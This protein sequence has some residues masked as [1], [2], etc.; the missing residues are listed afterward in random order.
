MV[1]MHVKKHAYIVDRAHAT[2]GPRAEAPRKYRVPS[3]TLSVSTPVSTLIPAPI[4]APS[5]TRIVGPNSEKNFS[6]KY[7]T[8]LGGAHAQTP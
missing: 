7:A 8:E 1:L 2:H 4:P 3:H 6:D 5:S